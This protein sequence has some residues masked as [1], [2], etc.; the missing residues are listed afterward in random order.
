MNDVGSCMKIRE[1]I[2]GSEGNEPILKY[3]LCMNSKRNDKWVNSHMKGLMEIWLANMDFQL[4]VDVNKVV[5]YMTKYVCKPEIEISKGLSKMVEK[6]INV[7]HHSGL[8]TKGILKRVMTKLLGNR[9]MVKQESCHLILGTPMVSSSHIFRTVNLNTSSRKLDLNCLD[10]ILNS[11]KEGKHTLEQPSILDLYMTRMNLDYWENEYVFNFE[12]YSTK[13]D[14]MNLY[15]FSLEYYVG[16]RNKGEEFYK[17]QKQSRKNIVISFSPYISGDP[18]G[19][20]FHE[21][22]RYSL[23][24]YRPFV[25]KIENAYDDLTEKNDLIQ[26]WI[27]VSGELKRLNKKFQKVYERSLKLLV[28]VL[29]KIIHVVNCLQELKIKTI[30]LIALKMM[31]SCSQLKKS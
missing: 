4:V 9:T 25:D 10:Y 21:Y 3:E 16:Y 5:S 20:N 24:K 11:E 22:C 19:Q 27:S 15:E 7:G 18:K 30:L 17:I 1:Y 23:I 6:V 8:G 13:F 12:N 28:V 29:Q 2:Q 14:K 31:T 26:K